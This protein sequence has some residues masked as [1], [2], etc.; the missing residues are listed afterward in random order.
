MASVVIWQHI[1]TFNICTEGKQWFEYCRKVKVGVLIIMSDSITESVTLTSTTLWYIEVIS[2]LQ[3][4]ERVLDKLRGELLEK[5][6]EIRA[7]RNDCN[8]LQ[9][10]E[11]DVSI[12]LEKL[13]KLVV[14]EIND[15]CRKTAHLLGVT[16]RKAH[17][18][19][20]VWYQHERTVLYV[21]RVWLHW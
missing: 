12:S 16:P 1:T 20:Y 3:D 14:N 8:S 21:V 7:L 17:S 18:T 11:S 2:L 15:E 4:T 19:G 13:E 5:E 6:N 10:S 9:Q